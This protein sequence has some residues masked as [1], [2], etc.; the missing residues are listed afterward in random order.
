MPDARPHW[1]CAMDHD[2]SKPMHA[3]AAWRW[4]LRD[5]GP[6]RFSLRKAQ[7]FIDVC[8]DCNRRLR[9]WWPGWVRLPLSETAI[10]RPK[11]AWI[12]PVTKGAS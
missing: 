9:P 11:E 5:G 4:W 7:G 3:R 1:I 10:P 2:A 8:D 6:G 12:E